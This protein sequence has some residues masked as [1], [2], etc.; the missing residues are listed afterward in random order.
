MPTDVPQLLAASTAAEPAERAGAAG[1]LSRLGPN[2]RAAAVPLAQ[3]CG[4][5]DEEVREWAVAAL[6]ELGVTTN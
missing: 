4:D 3:V 1:Q 5:Q 2:V 6:E